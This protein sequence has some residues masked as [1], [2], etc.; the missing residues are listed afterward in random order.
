MPG[1]VPIATSVCDTVVLL[2][3]LA[4]AEGD[5]TRAADLLRHM[6]AGLEPGVIVM[7]RH[8]AEQLGFTDEHVELQEQA[9]T[10]TALDPQGL[11]GTRMA[12]DAL[13]A[14]LIRRGW[15]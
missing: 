9:R 15:A 13:R 8:L 4:K 10:Y 7:S 11:N 14:E 12:A 6:G 1:Q 2:A 3:A 5:H